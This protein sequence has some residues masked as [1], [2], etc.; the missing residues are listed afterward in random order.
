MIRESFWTRAPG[1]TQALLWPEG[2][3][4]TLPLTNLGYLWL[5]GLGD[6]HRSGE[7]PSRAGPFVD[8]PKGPAWVQ[9]ILS[10]AEDAVPGKGKLLIL[11]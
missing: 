2:A 11:S 8:A 10:S 6:L 4:E 1:V 7:G 3:A 9:T 5:G